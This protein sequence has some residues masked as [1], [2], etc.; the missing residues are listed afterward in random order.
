MVGKAGNSIEDQ[1]R[2][3]TKKYKEIFRDGAYAHF[4]ACGDGF[5]GIYI[6]QIFK[7]YT[8]DMYSYVY[9]AQ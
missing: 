3:I 7:Q 5:A 1:K 9:R 6:C 4:L 8:L 2:Q